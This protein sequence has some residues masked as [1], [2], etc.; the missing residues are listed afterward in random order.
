MS[1]PFRGD[2]LYPFLA[3]F[4]GLTSVRDAIAVRIHV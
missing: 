2:G 4:P 3:E 1:I